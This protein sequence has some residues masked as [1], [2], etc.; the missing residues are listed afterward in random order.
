MTFA[1]TMLTVEECVLLTGIS[2]AT[3]YKSL[4]DGTLPSR[5]VGRAKR[6]VLVSDL[7]A[8]IGAPVAIARSA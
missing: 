1:R 6:R 7:E 5:I 4:A 8:F 3:L 2:R